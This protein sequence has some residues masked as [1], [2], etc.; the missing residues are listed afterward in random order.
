MLK[1]FTL[2]SENHLQ[3]NLDKCH[4]GKERL[5][6]LGHWVSAHG[7]LTDGGKIKAI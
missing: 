4:V 3:V 5:E 1:V 6:S 7:V 2:L